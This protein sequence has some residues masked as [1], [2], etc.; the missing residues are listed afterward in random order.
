MTKIPRRTRSGDAATRPDDDRARARRNRNRA[1]LAVLGGLVLLFYFVTIVR[2]GE[3]EEAVHGAGPGTAPAS[4][5]STPP[6]P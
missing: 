1:L 4:A 6:R 2:M 5:P 3:R